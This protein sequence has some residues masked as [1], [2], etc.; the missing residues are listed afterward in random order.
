MKSFCICI[1]GMVRGNFKAASS[2]N[3]MINELTS[4]GHK[5]DVFIDVWS[6]Q[7]VYSP[8]VQSKLTRRLPVKAFSLLSEKDKDIGNFKLKYPNLYEVLSSPIYQKLN[9]VA[10]EEVVNTVRINIEDQEEFKQSNSLF[11]RK[12]LLFKGN[13]NQVY[14]YYKIYN[15]MKLAK[16]YSLENNIEYDYAIRMRPDTLIKKFD[17]TG[18]IDSLRETSIKTMNISQDK[19]CGDILFYGDYDKMVDVSHIG[20]DILSK[21]TTAIFG[22]NKNYFSERLLTKYISHLGL[23]FHKQD[24]LKGTFPS[25]LSEYGM[26]INLPYESLYSAMKLDNINID[27]PWAVELLP[28]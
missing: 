6:I 4:R 11:D 24:S 16:N 13:Y 3:K 8:G 9:E 12:N 20:I 27:E 14:M 1:S 26:N 28:N 21:G 10:K 15:C 22:D 7:E 2:I 18:F 19:F 5:V 23:S 17:Y 25:E